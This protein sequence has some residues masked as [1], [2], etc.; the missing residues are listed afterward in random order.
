MAHE[1]TSTLASSRRGL[2]LT[3]RG[4][5]RTRRVAARAKAMRANLRPLPC[6][7]RMLDSVQSNFV[8]R[9]MII[10][11]GVDGIHPR[12]KRSQVKSRS[13]AVDAR[14]VRVRGAPVPG[15]RARAAA[16]KVKRMLVASVAG[17]MLA[18][19]AL[20]EKPPWAGGGKGADHGQWEGRE[21]RADGDARQG[22][23][24][25][26]RQDARQD[27]RRTD[28]GEPRSGNDFGDRHRTIVRDYYAQQFDSGRCPPGLAKKDNGCI[29]PGQ[30]RRWV[31]G[32]PLSHT[33]I[34]GLGRV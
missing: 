5:Y 31:V 27:G 12:R 11:Q 7:G 26:A 24:Q 17:V 14:V 20:A 18:S 22:G 32:E 25:S 4:E 23:G 9:R 21:V 15:R 8:R 30:V 6:C 1:K 19:P 3:G 16:S 2:R 10:V 33:A 34:N 13:K 29:P 28:R